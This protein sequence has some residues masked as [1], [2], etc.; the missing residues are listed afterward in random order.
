M[1]GEDGDLGAVH[2]NHPA[3]QVL[4]LALQHLHVVAVRELVERVLLVPGSDVN[5]QPLRSF[6]E[7]GLG[8]CAYERSLNCFQH[9][10][11]VSMGGIDLNTIIR[12]PRRTSL[13]SNVVTV[14]SCRR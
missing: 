8:R 4:Q 10:E 2:G 5:V 1:L 7:S 9:L 12:V 11:L 6:L 14:Q 3:L 13:G